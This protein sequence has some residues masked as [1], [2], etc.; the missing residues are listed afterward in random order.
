[1]SVLRSTCGVFAAA[2]TLS[3]VAAP[4][5]AGE[6]EA[7]GLIL[8]QNGDVIVT[9]DGAT[10]TGEIEVHHDETTDP[11]TVHFVD[12]LGNEFQS[13]PVE[14]SLGHMIGDTGIASWTAT[15]DWEFQL[16]GVTEGMT[17]L[18]LSIFHIPEGHDDYV[19]PAI[20]IHVVE[21]HAEAEGLVL[22]EDGEVIVTVDGAVVT[23]EI[24]IHPGES[25]GILTVAFV[26]EMGVEFVPDE[27]DFSLD[28]VIG[29]TGIATFVSLGDWSF[30]LDAVS[31]GVTDIQLGILHDGHLDYQSPA[32]EIHV[33]EHHEEAEGLVLRIDGAEVLRVEG[34]VVTGEL[35]APLGGWT[36]TVVVTFLAEDGDEFV[37]DE[38]E[39]FVLTET[40][41]DPA[42]IT[43]EKIGDYSFRIHGDTSGP[44]TMQLGIFHE[45]HF[46]YQSPD[47]PVMVDPTVGVADAVP[48]G[49]ALWV[50]APV[51]NPA[52]G[53]A[54]V[55]LSLAE[56]QR[57]DVGLF[58]VSGRRVATLATGLTAA[59]LHRLDIDA[60][61]VGAG[62]HF[63]RVQTPGSVTSRKLIIQR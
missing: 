58:D 7:D 42:A 60:T 63:I 50:G 33:E 61:R 35:I 28:Q 41:A 37:P 3:S 20:E 49:G 39:E 36:E 8:R 18:T 30:R 12:D 26:D 38:P 23:G 55:Q 10:V 27:P 43:F 34:A 44:T 47:L 59:G 17:D 57:I 45:G 22:R 1:M 40:L 31:E 53:S 4:V 46:D 54:S 5:L 13:D 6:V 9:V 52:L 25:T 15:G 29:D 16:T 19:S 51:P 56:A 11:I 14:F 62:V 21:E 24:G 32:I 48:G 2:L